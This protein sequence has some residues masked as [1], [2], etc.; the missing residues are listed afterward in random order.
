MTKSTSLFEDLPQPGDYGHGKFCARI[1]RTRLADT[2]SMS[3]PIQFKLCPLKA[4]KDIKELRAGDFVRE[5]NPQKTKKRCGEVLMILQNSVKDPTV[6][7]VEVDPEN[8]L[9][10]IQGLTV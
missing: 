8:S 2:G 10:Y 5:R 9:I 3:L 6:E 7:C 1:A 4:E